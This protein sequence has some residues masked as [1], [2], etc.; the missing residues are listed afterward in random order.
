MEDEVK[1]NGGMG[2]YEHSKETVV[3]S[4]KGCGK[5]MCKECSEK[6]E[7]K[8][9]D[10]CEKE[11][12]KQEE[13]K[14][15]KNLNHSEDCF[16]EARKIYMKQVIL[17][18]VLGIGGLILGISQG[19]GIGNAISIAWALAGFPIGWEKVKNLL[20]SDTLMW[21]VVLTKSLWI[22]AIFVQLL[23]ALII[24]FVLLPIR[25]FQMIKGLIDSKDGLKK[26][27]EL[28]K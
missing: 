1:T 6:Y 4:C 7:S 27:E 28:K 24:G 13:K 17:A 19:A 11:R 21:L 8:L 25:I 22:I 23:L 15:Q 16:K 10:N 18:S 26:V 12:A 14:K 3:A 9:C 20:A 5:F 2:C